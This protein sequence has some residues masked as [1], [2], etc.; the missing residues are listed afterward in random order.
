MDS[1]WEELGLPG[2]ER[3]EQVVKVTR[4][5]R[6]EWGWGVGFLPWG[7]RAVGG[8]AVRSRGTQAGVLLRGQPCLLAVVG[9]EFVGLGVF[10][11]GGD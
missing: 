8:P 4:R 5:A 6:G 3:E 9:D 11:P 10:L 2:V 7:S 1:S